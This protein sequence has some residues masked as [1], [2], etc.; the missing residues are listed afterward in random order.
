VDNELDRGFEEF[1]NYGGVFPNRPDI[2][3]S[4][5]R[6]AGRVA[7]RIGRTL[8]SLNQPIQDWVTHNNL[9]LDIML[10]PLI[11][12]FWQR[13]INFKGNT[14]QSLGDLVGYLRTR[15]KKGAER[16]IFAFLNLMETHLP[17]GP[18]AR[19]VRRFVPYYHSDRQARSFMQS[20]N[21]ET[22]RWITPI[23]EPFT[24]LED[25]VLNDMYDAEVAFEDH[26]LRQ[27]L[28]YLDQPEIRDNT[29]VILMADHGEG[30]NHHDYVG[31]SLVT[32]D[33]LVHVPLILRY[34]RLYPEGKRIST[35]VSTRRVF[36]T[37]LEAAGVSPANAQ[38]TAEEARNL[39]LT[40]SL[41]GSD[42][43]QGI[44]FTE[45]FP[46]KTLLALME[47]K[48]PKVIDAFRCRATRRAIFSSSLDSYKLITIDN[49]P[50][51]LFDVNTDPPELCNLIS[52]QPQIAVALERLLKGEIAKAEARRPTS[53]PPSSFSLNNDK[54]LAD[55]LRGLGYIE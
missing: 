15:Q 52:E 47:N 41:N 16:P 18:P 7:Q 38:S 28:E 23:T 46:Q 29:L 1:Y 49:Q 35:P 26:L 44:V 37:A 17:Y 33:D 40:R 19:F 55:R 42:P 54:N 27:L 25:H 2:S 51:E 36:H 9:L 5:P 14:R 13:Y 22:Y 31:H 8:N 43:E 39:S 32:Y 50:E 3:E 4:R 24:E 10:H 48:A 11:V 45:A 20:Y 30:V 21:Y 34:P 53:L 6:A 12:P